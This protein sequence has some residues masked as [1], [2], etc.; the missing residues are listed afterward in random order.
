M[1]TDIELTT[2]LVV[3]FQ[4]LDKSTMRINE[5]IHKSNANAS[6]NSSIIWIWVDKVEGKF[7]S[8]NF[9]PLKPSLYVSQTLT[10]ISSDFFVESFLT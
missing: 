5:K 6:C 7:S 4:I 8:F 3:I 1:T 9:A 2:K 10:D